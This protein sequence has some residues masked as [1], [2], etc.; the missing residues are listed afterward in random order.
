M[1]S[2]RSKESKQPAYDRQN[3][4]RRLERKAVRYEKKAEAEERNGSVK[5]ARSLRDA[6]QNLRRDADKLRGI[7]TQDLREDTKAGKNLRTRV[8]SAMKRSEEAR[9]KPK[10]SE[11]EALND[12]GKVLLDDTAA[13]HRFFA[14]TKDI[15]KGTTTYEERYEA[16]QRAFWKPEDGDK[17][18]N[19]YETIK[20][21]EKTTEMDI[22]SGSELDAKYKRGSSNREFW[23]G[24]HI[25]RGLNRMVRY[26]NE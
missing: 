11:Y 21:V 24:S 9:F 19:I 20:R 14:V 7:K 8:S 6:A 18:P 26:L 23:K 2:K 16:I 15:W 22:L 10:E 5:Y 12:L 13:G 3:A 25:R 17:L 4:R 1:A